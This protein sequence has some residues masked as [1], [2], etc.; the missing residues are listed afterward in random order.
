M[1]MNLILFPCLISIMNM[2]LTFSFFI[3]LF[4]DLI[5][6]VNPYRFESDFYLFEFAN[7]HLAKK[8]DLI[9]C[10][11]AWLNASEDEPSNHAI[12]YWVERLRPL[13]QTRAAVAICNRLGKEERSFVGHSCL[14]QFQPSG[15]QVMHCGDQEGLYVL[16][17]DL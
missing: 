11:M 1:G 16:E 12:P 15:V 4:Y 14:I 17:V 5:T 3:I 7:F 10:S 9:L 13:D 6:D 8:S 2:K